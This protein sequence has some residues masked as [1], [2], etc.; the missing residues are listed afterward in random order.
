MHINIVPNEAM[1]YMNLY[2]VLTHGYQ[3]EAS[4]SQAISKNDAAAPIIISVL[5][6]I[7]TIALGSFFNSFLIVQPTEMRRMD[8]LEIHSIMNNMSQNPCL[9]LQN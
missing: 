8:A 6:M 2:P 5:S 1:T 3:I 7:D 9:F 4:M